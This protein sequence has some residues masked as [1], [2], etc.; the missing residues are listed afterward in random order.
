MLY[1]ASGKGIHRPLKSKRDEPAGHQYRAQVSLIFRLYFTASLLQQTT[2][3]HDDRFED[4]K[5]RFI[6]IVFAVMCS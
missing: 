4:K 2:S 3:E 5:G 1:A 6:R